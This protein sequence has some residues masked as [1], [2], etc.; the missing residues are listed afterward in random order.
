MMKAKPAVV[1]APTPSAQPTVVTAPTPSVFQKMMAAEPTLVAPTPSARPIPVA[2]VSSTKPA[3]VAPTL[4]V[5]ECPAD[6]HDLH[7]DWLDDNSKKAP[8]PN[9]LRGQIRKFLAATGCKIT[10]FQKII[11]VNSNSYNKYMNGKYKDQWSATANSTY[12]SAAYFFWREKKLGKKALA[13]R[14]TAAQPTRP[15]LPDISTVTLESTD[16]YLTPKETRK[17]LTSLCSSYA[18][19]QA[20]IAKACGAPNANAMSRFMSAGGEFGG[21]DQDFYE[22]AAIYLEKLRVKLGKPKS[23]KRKALETEA[24]DHPGK[25]PF[26]GVDLSQKVWCIGGSVP[27]KSKD[28]LGRTT[29]SYHTF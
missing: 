16:V 19:T 3:A 17:E 2:P 29:L 23:K 15:G 12:S 13:K 27:C 8:T 9:T 6:Y 24:A 7:D 5:G 25:R 18:C 21:R 14:W 1:T 10:A 28:D 11:G 22:L 26:L 20:S 4:A